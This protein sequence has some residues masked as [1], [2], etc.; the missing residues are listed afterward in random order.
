MK[1]QGSFLLEIRLQEKNHDSRLGYDDLYEK[2]SLSQ[3]DS[4]YLWLAKQFNLPDH[5]T[6]LDLACGAGEMVR[7]AGLRGMRAVGLDISDVVARAASWHVQ[8]YGTIG[9]GQGE[10][11]PFAD[12]CFDC[13]T[14]IGSLE[15]F[16]DPAQG[17]REMA[18]VLNSQGRAY[19]LVPNT[20]S[21]LTNILIAWR[22][23]ITSIDQQPIQRYGA[24]MD[25]ANLLEN[26]GL[27]V[28]KT[29]KYERA[30]PQRLSDWGYYFRNPKQM[31][32][33]LAT[34]FVPLNLAFC[35]IFICGKG[36]LQRE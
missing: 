23:G 9:I 36:Y 11:I 22:K 4:F 30:W 16:Q 15:H 28:L 17:V 26:N 29:M 13:V 21:L 12:D 7:L 19:V 35:F 14:N 18:R 8:S 6:L 5:G 32:R 34:P 3:I 25:W 27:H 31:I 24:R 2:T 20:F 10:S 33:L 1:Q